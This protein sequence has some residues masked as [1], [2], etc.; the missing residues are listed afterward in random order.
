MSGL[1]ILGGFVSLNQ[2]KHKIKPIKFMIDEK[3]QGRRNGNLVKIDGKKFP[4]FSFGYDS[5]PP[6]IG[7]NE[8][9]ICLK[10]L[11]FIYLFL[12]ILFYF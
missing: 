6:T 11:L 2:I 9:P 1:C 5:H 7:P 12:F 4:I 10:F 8:N 3:R